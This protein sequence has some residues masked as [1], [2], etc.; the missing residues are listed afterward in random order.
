VLRHHVALRDGTGREGNR[1]ATLGVSSLTYA[2]ATWTQT[3][4][5]WCAS[6]IRTFEYLGCVPELVVP[7]N[8]N[9]AVLRPCRYEPRLN[10]TYEELA[11]HYAS[12]ILPAR[13]RHPRD[14]AKAEN[15][16]LLAE[17]WILARLRDHTFF[18]LS[19][20]NAEIAILREQLND[21]PFKK[22]PGSRY[23]AEFCYRF[24]RRFHLPIM[25]CQLARVALRTPP[26]PYRL[27][28]LAEVHW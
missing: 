25:L 21:K 13:V 9:T 22:L 11:E 19:E 4:P 28:K 26:L 17:R 15:A 5:D 23:L 3:L 6:H 2:E 7:D 20:L 1:R 18:S 8:P 12:A 24:N 16:V 27:A 10:R 14:K